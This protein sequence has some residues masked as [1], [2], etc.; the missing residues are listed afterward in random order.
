MQLLR[1]VPFFALEHISAV[2]GCPYCL[3]FFV[4]RLIGHER[5]AGFLLPSRCGEQ[6]NLIQMNPAGEYVGRVIHAVL[7]RGSIGLCGH[8]PDVG[9]FP[10]TPTRFKLLQ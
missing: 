6:H 9:R 4:S 7:L 5:D 3:V 8:E 2:K 1:G 10:R